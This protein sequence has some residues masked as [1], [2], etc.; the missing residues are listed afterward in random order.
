MYGLKHPSAS[1]ITL[2]TFPMEVCR[3]KHRGWAPVLLYGSKL[4]VDAATDG[5]VWRGPSDFISLPTTAGPCSL[6]STSADDTALGTGAQ[7]VL[8]TGVD[9]NWD[10]LTELKALDGLTPVV[11]SADFLR[12]NE[13]RVLAAGTG[14]TNAG[15]ITAS[16]G[17]GVSG[18][19]IAGDSVTLQF[20]YTVP[21][22]HTL[23]VLN[24]SVWQARDN[25]ATTSLRVRPD[26]LPWYRT[27]STETYRNQYIAEL[28][29]AAC[30]FGKTDVRLTAK[31]IAMGGT[32]AVFASMT[33]MLENTL[34]SE[35]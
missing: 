3:R 9:A 19:I 29:G 16:I 11:T 13:L 31:Q 1:R 6:L 28:F 21:A 14:E 5:S 12:I 34:I 35:V 7:N 30:L 17:G 10:P 24:T 32:T 18:I 33:G 27:G 22:N 2:P 4:D 25:A 20:G 26:G 15:D 23:H 8:V